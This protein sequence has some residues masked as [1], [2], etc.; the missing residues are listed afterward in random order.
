[1]VLSD[2]VVLI[3][4]ASGALGRAVS[5]K[6]AAAGARVAL[7]GRKR[8]P[9]D[10]LASGLVREFGLSGDRAMVQASDLGKSDEVRA[11]VEAVAGR[12]GGVDALVN[13]AGGW[14]GGKTLAELSD[15]E[16]DSALEMNLRSA[17]LVNRAVLPFMV[18]KG[19]GRIVN[20]SSR[21]AESPGPKQAAY[22]VAKAGVIALTG[23]IAA[24]YRKNGIAA[25]V[26]LPS[27]IDT[28]SNRSQMPDADASRWVH[29]QELASLIVYLLS[30]EG[31]SLNGAAIPVYGRV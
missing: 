7:T 12:W 19:W 1:L 10:E 30:D 21:A 18:K 6:I 31:G 23:S 24:E 27:I 20:I 9:L 14:R 3:T 29:P 25:N 5:G 4:G 17:F 8:E 28:P 16:W 26:I 13:L 11:L 15:E 2:R 22:N